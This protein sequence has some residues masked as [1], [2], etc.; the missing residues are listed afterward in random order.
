[1]ELGRARTVLGCG[2]PKQSY[3]HTLGVLKIP[4]DFAVGE[5]AAYVQAPK[6]KVAGAVLCSAFHLPDHGFARAICGGA[7]QMFGPRPVEEVP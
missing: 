7:P 6:L 5:P 4:Y 2:N 1:M 3:S